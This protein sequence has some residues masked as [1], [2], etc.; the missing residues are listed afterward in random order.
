LEKYPEIDLIYKK[1]MKQMEKIQILMI[2]EGLVE[3]KQKINSTDFSFLPF[4]SYHYD[5]ICKIQEKIQDSK[6]KKTLIEHLNDPL[7]PL[8]GILVNVP[9]EEVVVK[10]MI[11]DLFAKA[12][13]SKI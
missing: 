10:S 9:D 6:D 7:P 5:L 2:L 1:A 4:Y 13:C 12:V 11:S 8:T 3:S